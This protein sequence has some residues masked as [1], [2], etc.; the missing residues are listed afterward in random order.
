MFFSLPSASGRL[1]E[2]IVTLTFMAV[3][4]SPQEDQKTKVYEESEGKTTLKH[5][6]TQIQSQFVFFFPGQEWVLADLFLSILKYIRDVF[7]C[8]SG[9]VCLAACQCTAAHVA[10]EASLA[11]KA[12]QQANPGQNAYCLM[13][14]LTS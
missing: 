2:Q 7:V 5:F 8:V 4:I 14:M 6:L 3:P 13:E 9:L 10:W 1:K 11:C 12:V